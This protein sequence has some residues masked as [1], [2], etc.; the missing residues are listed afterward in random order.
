MGRMVSFISPRVAE[1]VD[2]ESQPLDHDEVRIS[3]LFSGISAG[4]E[5]TAYRGTN[6]YL[7]KKWD[8]ER[9]LFVDGSTSFEYP[10]NGWGYE[11]VGEVTEVGSGVTTVKV[12]DVVWG[13]WG[14]RTETI[15]KVERAEKRILA[16][17]A[18][19]RIGIFSHI[20]AI[21]LNVVLA[22]VALAGTLVI[23]PAT[24]EIICLTERSRVGDVSWPRKYFWATM[25]VAF[26]DQLLG[27]STCSCLKPPTAA[28]RDSHSTSSNGCVPAVVKRRGMESP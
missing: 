16:E 3:T 22:T 15:Q 11:E 17:G 21:A 4:T 9:R 12:G 24:R 5:L 19:P 7:N 20:G 14:H 13:T 1:V 28:V 27:N 6:P 2:E 26:C 8:E 10:V 18:D 23:V 25:L